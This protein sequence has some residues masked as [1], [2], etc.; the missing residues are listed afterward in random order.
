MKKGL[1]LLAVILTSYS[2]CNTYIYIVVSRRATRYATPL[3]RFSAK[4][5]RVLH[6]A[7]IVEI[8]VANILCHPFLKQPLLHMEPSSIDDYVSQLLVNTPKGFGSYINS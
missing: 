7:I 1:C 6:L 5:H 3:D 8:Y 2:S 4:C